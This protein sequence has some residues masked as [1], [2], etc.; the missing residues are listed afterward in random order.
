MTDI[1]HAAV[2]AREDA[3][4]SS[5]E[6]GVQLHTAPETGL[7]AYPYPALK[8]GIRPDN[9]DLN[10]FIAQDESGNT[11][12]RVVANPYQVNRY[13]ALTT[14]VDVELF[15]VFT[16]PVSD[17]HATSLDEDQWISLANAPEWLRDAVLP[18]LAEVDAD[19]ADSLS[20]QQ[21]RHEKL[22][23]AGAHA[24]AY[25]NG[26]LAEFEERFPSDTPADAADGLRQIRTL[27]GELANTD[28]ELAAAELSRR[29]SVGV[30]GVLV[31]ARELRAG[32]YISLAHLASHFPDDHAWTGERYA[33]I[34]R[35]DVTGIGGNVTLTLDERTTLT[36]PTG[37][38]LPA[39][40]YEYD[41]RL[42]TGSALIAELVSSNETIYRNDMV[43]RSHEFV[44]H[45]N[46][47]LG[48]TSGHPAYI[49][50]IAPTLDGAR[51]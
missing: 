8:N 36:L 23:A 38:R 31:D 11:I 45:Y 24:T 18:S 46:Q 50:T 33:A 41:G 30:G 51:L 14:D 9:V 16:L 26:Y 12:W 15:P 6:F 27:D 34:T 21:T 47:Q 25:D 2:A 17:E 48:L 37:A 35:A 5:G 32:D 43:A 28:R 19:D 4:M 13:G 39:L 1:S 10:V 22:I 42:F 40:G 20:W 29:A 3:R 49:E 7:N 44:T